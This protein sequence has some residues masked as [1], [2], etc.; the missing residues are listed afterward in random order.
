MSFYGDDISIDKLMEGLKGLFNQQKSFVQPSAAQNAKP[1]TNTPAESTGYKAPIHDG[2]HNLGGF[3]PGMVRY[4]DDPNAKKGRGHFGV[5]MSAS[6][7]TPVYALSEGV[8]NTVSTDKMGGNIVG[9]NH[10][11]EIWSYYAHL[12][13]AKIH[14]GDKVDTNTI[15]GTVGNTGNPGNPK[16]PL[17]TQEGGRTWP[18]LHFGVKEHGS[19]VDPAKFFSIPTYDPNFAK[20]P[21][22]FEKFWVS[23][24]AKQEAEA[25]NMKEH[26]SQR[27]VA[28]T[29][30]VGRLAKLANQFYKLV[31]E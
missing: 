21:G 25:F 28:F 17:K 13:T 31:S 18:H 4:D 30:D 2:W 12:S 3:D 19:W 22:K 9:V 10:A 20:N 23:D 14:V 16:D 11:N 29:R 5:D 1:S 6:A 24:S 8:V 26:T 27:R 15:V 7:G